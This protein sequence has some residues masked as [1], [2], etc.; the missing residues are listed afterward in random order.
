[1][2]DTDWFR[3]AMDGAIGLASGIGGAIVWAFR[4]GRSS[5]ENEQRIKDDYDGKINK[6]RLDFQ[7]ELASHNGMIMAVERETLARIETLRLETGEMGQ[8]IRQ[9]I[10]DV[11]ISSRDRLDEATNSIRESI[12]KLG[13]RLEN[14]IDRI[15]INKAVQ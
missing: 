15:I 2:A 4:I 14:K 8:A 13:E 7:G 11:E 9:R 6:L 10:H 1:M 3:I 12:D 5:S